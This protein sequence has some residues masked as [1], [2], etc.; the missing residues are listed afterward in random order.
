M[1]TGRQMPSHVVIIGIILKASGYGLIACLTALNGCAI[2]RVLMRLAIA[3]SSERSCAPDSTAWVRISI[4]LSD[5]PG[6]VQCGYSLGERAGS[7][8]RGQ[9]I[10]VKGTATKRYDVV[11]VRTG[12]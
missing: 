2:S 3:G 11:H 4:H 8:S 6:V 9:Q 7:A 12:S 1:R 5:S 10:K